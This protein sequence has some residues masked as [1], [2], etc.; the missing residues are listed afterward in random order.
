MYR[1]LSCIPGFFGHAGAG[2]A[3]EHKYC[4]LGR[5]C[6]LDQQTG[7]GECVCLDRCKPHYKPVCGS[8]GRL[9]QNHCELH[10]ASCLGHHRITIMHS[11]ECFYKGEV[12]ALSL[13]LSLSLCTLRSVLL[14]VSPEAP[15]PQALHSASRQG[16][17]ETSQHS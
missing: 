16:A 2:T 7:L 11:E 8:D 14:S 6:V 10:R 9:Y 13:S 12:T 4:G 3:C 15:G 5:H 1:P 17:A